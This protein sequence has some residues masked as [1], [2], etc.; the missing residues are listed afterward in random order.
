R[1]DALLLRRRSA[2]HVEN[3]FFHDRPVQ[4]VDAITERNLRERQTKADPIRRQMVDVIQINSADRQ[5]AK[6]LDRR[7]A[8]DVREHSR[9]R[10][11]SKGNESAETARFILKLAKL[12]QMIDT[13][14]E[15]FDM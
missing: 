2:R 1:G 13:L 4:I 3:F 7:R 12:A 9:L 11:E 6:L 10:L 15:S 14:L 8:L 5:V